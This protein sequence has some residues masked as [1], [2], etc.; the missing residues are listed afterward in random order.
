MEE[1]P[2]RIF[3][4]F[5]YKEI[6]HMNDL[7]HCFRREREALANLDLDALWEISREK[8]ET[9]SKMASDRRAAGLGTGRGADERQSFRS[10]IMASVPAADRAE[11]EK[12][13]DTV[14]GLKG[15]AEAMRK[16]NLSL[17]DH[18]LQF[19]DGM[20]S[21]ITGEAYAEVSYNGKCQV[22][23]AGGSLLLSREA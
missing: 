10:R 20:I 9:C 6:M 8:E 23:R 3:E 4:A 14:V 11:I 19:L 18:S 5:L 21:I 7:L 2:I 22:N 13:L 15:E 12:L 17:I 1:T 16:E